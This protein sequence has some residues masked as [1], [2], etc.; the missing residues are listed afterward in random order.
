MP[1][2]FRVY[3]MNMVLKTFGRRSDLHAAARIVVLKK[4]ENTCSTLMN[5]EAREVLTQELVRLQQFVDSESKNG[6]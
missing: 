2:L 1:F 6:R 4:F 3:E 5:T